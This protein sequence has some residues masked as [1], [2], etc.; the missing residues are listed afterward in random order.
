MDVFTQLAPGVIVLDPVELKTNNSMKAKNIILI[1][2]LGLFILTGCSDFKEIQEEGMEPMI[3]TYIDSVEVIEANGFLLRPNE[4]QL[5]NDTLLGVS[6]IFSKGIWIFNKVN[7]LEELSFIN[8]TYQDISFYPTKVFWNDYPTLFILDGLSQNILKLELGTLQSEYGLQ[9][10]KIIL[11]LPEGTRVLPTSKSFWVDDQY[12]YLELS[13]E[14]TPKTSKEFYTKSG[15]FI[16]VFNNDGSFEKRMIS[17]PQSLTEF[18]GFLEPSQVYSSGFKNKNT[19]IFSFPSEKILMTISQLPD[20][21]E[22]FYVPIPKSK[23]FDYN[24]PLLEKEFSINTETKNPQLH[25]FGDIK[26]DGDNYYLQSYMKD[27]QNLE[28]WSLKSHIVK[29]NSKS[30]SWSESIDPKEFIHFGE[31][32]GVKND[33]LYILDA[34]MVNKE[35]KYLKK[36]VLRKFNSN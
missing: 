22:T 13:P 27:N 29:Y 7:G 15:D 21:P 9:I 33:T 31:L 4:T 32:A 18:E 6:S 28:N 10:Q 2:F 36:A 3:L 23:Y 24:L 1:A 8:G 12:F 34:G 11:D 5:I 30:E 26:T 16:G 19:S 20:S 17:Y 14:N 25:F 35:Q